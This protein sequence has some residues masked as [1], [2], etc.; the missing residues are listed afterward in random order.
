MAKGFCGAPDEDLRNRVTALENKKS[1]K[2]IS[3]AK[4]IPFLGAYIGSSLARHIIPLNI[5]ID[6]YT[7]TPNITHAYI[8]KNAS[9]VEISYVE[10][11]ASAGRCY[12]WCSNPSG[13]TVS[14]GMSGYYCFEG[15]ITLT[16]K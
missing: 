7:V 8:F 13:V 14:D 16:A 15:T 12:L 5:D 10:L 6:S 2:T 9:W 4:S 1:T 3:L 11:T